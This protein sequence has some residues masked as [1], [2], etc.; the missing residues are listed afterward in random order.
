MPFKRVASGI[1]LVGGESLTYPNDCLV[2]LVAG[3]PVLLVDAGASRV[4]RR[5][6]DNIAETGLDPLDIA[7]CL[8]THC[9]VDHIGG[10]QAVRETAGC[11]LA[12]HEDDAAAIQTGDPIRTAASWY[13]VKLPKLALDDVLIGEAGEFAGVQW[14]HTP[15]HT[16][17]SLAA[18]LDVDDGRVL[19]A[20]DVHGPF[21]PEF[22]SDLDA[23][24]ASMERLLALE[25]DVLCE[26]HYGVFR[27][28]DEVARYIRSQL[29]ANS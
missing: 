22:G 2:Y 8:L 24:R 10:A 15:G 17:G 3:P 28:R 12:A 20:Q 4:A 18:W 27:G 11:A 7:Y 21:T 1:F 6:L 16:P 29:A 23:W 25:A 26:G 14:V 19:F 5:L 9:H 13:N